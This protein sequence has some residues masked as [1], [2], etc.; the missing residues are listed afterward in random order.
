V[1]RARDQLLLLKQ[2]GSVERYTERFQALALD[3]PNL[4]PA[5]ALHQYLHGLKPKIRADVMRR[6]PTVLEDAIRQADEAE[7]IFQDAYSYDQPAKQ[8]RPGNRFGNNRSFP[9][10]HTGS[11]PT[12]MDLGAMGDQRRERL[13]PEEREYLK[14]HNGCMYCRSLSH[15][16]DKCPDLKAKDAKRGRF[17]PGNGRRAR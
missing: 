7:A 17:Q 13:T 9:S 4:D 11:G 14:L 5:Q 16:I 2:T 15:T 10:R 12:P 3:I 1:Q 6:Q 8:L